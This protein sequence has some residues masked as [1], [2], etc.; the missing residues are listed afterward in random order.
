MRIGLSGQ[1]IGV[2][3][4]GVAYLYVKEALKELNLTLPVLKL[5]FFYPLPEKRIRE[6][7]KGL[8]K[9]LVAE[10]LEPYLEKE[11]ARLAK[12]S[13]CK[14]LFITTHSAHIMVF[15]LITTGQ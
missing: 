15:G 13:N 9:V 1:K 14:L 11:T 3:T 2:I 4:S 7:L 5:D 12:E 8:K 6:F 10:E